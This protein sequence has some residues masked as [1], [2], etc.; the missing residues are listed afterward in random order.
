LH[1]RLN[2]SKLFD[3]YP[4]HKPSSSH[5]AR[6]LLK[7]TATELTDKSGV[8][9]DTIRRFELM[10]GVPSR[11]ARSIETIQKALEQVGVKFIGTSHNQPGDHLKKK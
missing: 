3:L 10:S 7:I 5:V 1:D 2:L 4:Y 9:I 8:V 11:N 6:Q